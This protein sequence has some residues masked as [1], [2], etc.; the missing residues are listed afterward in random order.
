[1]KIFR[2]LLSLFLAFVIF[3]G[4]TPSA[5]AFC[6]FYVAKADSKLYNKAKNKESNKRNIFILG[7]GY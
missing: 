7:I 3:I 1:M 6:G 5:L 2:L 4:F